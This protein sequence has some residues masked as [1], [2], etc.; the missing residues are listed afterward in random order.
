MDD[1]RALRG[2]ETTIPL[3]ASHSAHLDLVR[4][5]AAL[6][7]LDWLGPE[8]AGAAVGTSSLRR[9]STYLEL[10]IKDGSATAPIRKAALIDIGI[11][12]VVGDAVVVEVRWQSATLAPLFPVFAGRL[13]ILEAGLYLDGRYVPPFG[14]IGLVI[15]ESLLGFIARRS[16]H[17]FL[18]RLAA[19]L[20][21]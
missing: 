5:R 14:R 21:E 15:D 13:H 19:H 2:A 16:A 10:P 18:A 11:P 20:A 3:R 9:V 4:A 6:V 8:Q 17:A 12:T 1:N 7:D